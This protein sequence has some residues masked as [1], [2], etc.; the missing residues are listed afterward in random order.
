ADEIGD[1]EGEL[2][3]FVNLGVA[4]N[5]GGLYREA[6]PCFHKA[7]VLAQSFSGLRKHRGAILAN[8]SQSHFYLSEIV[9]GFEAICG[10]LADTAEPV[11]ATSALSR[12]VREFTYVQLALELGKLAHARE[13][14]EMCTRYAQLA[15]TIRTQSMARI[16]ASLCEI[17]GGD[18]EKGL[19][20][21]ELVLT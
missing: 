4:L 15:N 16:A 12:T 18:A 14:S 9:R 20:E 11:D 1:T 10:A 6:I 8:L 5:Y 13:H 19:S 3:G 21:L 7:I 2:I 17:H